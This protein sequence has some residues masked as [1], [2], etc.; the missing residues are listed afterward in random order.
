MTPCPRC[1]RPRVPLLDL[2]VAAQRA[3]KALDSMR[4]ALPDDLTRGVRQVASGLA[5]H[6]G[7]CAPRQEELL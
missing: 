4:F 1:G 2:A 5:C 3:R 7:L 6:A